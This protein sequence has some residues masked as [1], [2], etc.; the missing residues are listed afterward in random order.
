MVLPLLMCSV[1]TQEFYFTCK[2]TSGSYFAF[3]TWRNKS[4]NFFMDN[5][6]Y[7]GLE[8]ND[9]LARDCTE[10]HDLYLVFGSVRLEI[11]IWI[12]SG[13][14]WSYLR[15][16]SSSLHEPLSFISTLQCKDLC[17]S[18]SQSVNING[19]QL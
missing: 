6:F 1:N 17:G 16:W 18:S 12:K 2:D 14:L 9:F 7:L 3:K 15:M 19:A 10:F 4:Y 11:C 13:A 5:L 8:L